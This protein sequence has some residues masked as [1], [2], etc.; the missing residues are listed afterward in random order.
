MLQEAHYNPICHATSK[1]PRTLCRQEHI[2]PHI[3]AKVSSLQGIGWTKRSHINLPNGTFSSPFILHLLSNTC[4]V[5]TISDK[6]Y[7]PVQVPSTSMFT[8]FPSPQTDK[9][10][11]VLNPGVGLNG[12]I[13]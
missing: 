13:Q 2:Q 7:R 5:F 4:K 3:A 9:Y 6:H 1:V 8:S 12:L 10:T 11:Q